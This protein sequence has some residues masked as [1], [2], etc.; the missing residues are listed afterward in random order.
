MNSKARGKRM[1]CPKREK[2]D[3]SDQA[4][5]VNRNLHLVFRGPQQLL[6]KLNLIGV[7]VQI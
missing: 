2:E 5:R 1:P 4:K 7:V 6:A 3:P